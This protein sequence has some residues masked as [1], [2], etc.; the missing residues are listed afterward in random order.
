[1]ENVIDIQ[2]RAGG[3]ASAARLPAQV[4]FDRRELSTIMNIYGRFVSAGLWRDYAISMEREEASFSAFERAADRPDVRIIKNPSLSRKQGAYALMG[5]HGDILKRGHDLKSLLSLL[6][7]K[8]M[9]V[10]EG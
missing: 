1:M 3:G 2:S 4:A 5:R 10:V 8:L 9:K 6:E 7:R